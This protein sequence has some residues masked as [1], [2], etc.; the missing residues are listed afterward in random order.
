MYARLESRFAGRHRQFEDSLVRYGADLQDMQIKVCTLETKVL[1][2]VK[3]QFG[4]LAAAITNTLQLSNGQAAILQDL[5]NDHLQQLATTA[6]LQ[7]PRGTFTIDLQ[8]WT[9]TQRT[10]ARTTRDQSW[11]RD[12]RLRNI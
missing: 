9:D 1:E 8:Q 4:R 12:P 2:M 6:Q 10:N 3:T 5:V 7:P 11:T